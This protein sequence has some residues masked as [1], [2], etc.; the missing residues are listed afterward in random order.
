VESIGHISV[1]VAYIARCI[2][3]NMILRK[4]TNWIYSFCTIE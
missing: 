3:E 1:L 2:V 4:R